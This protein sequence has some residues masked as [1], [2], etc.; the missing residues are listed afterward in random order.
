[1]GESRS[2]DLKRYLPEVR[3]TNCAEM[4]EDSVRLILSVL[5]VIGFVLLALVIFL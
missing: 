4:T 2:E 3:Y 1:M 5:L